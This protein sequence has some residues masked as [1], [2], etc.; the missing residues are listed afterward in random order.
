[1]KPGPNEKVYPVAKIAT[2][3]E[4]LASEGVSPVDALAG[5]RLSVTQLRSPATRVSANQVLQSYRNAIRLSRNPQFAYHTGLRFHVSTY[6]MY[7]FA[8]LSSPNFRGTMAFAMKYHQLAAPLV[9]IDFKEQDNTAMWTIVPK[10][11]P[12]TD[13]LLYKFVVDLQMA[14]HLS[15]HRDVMGPSFRPSELHF[16]FGRPRGGKKDSAIFDCPVLYGQPENSF[17]FDAHWLDGRPNLGNAVTYAELC[18]LCDR[19]ANELQLSAG[20]AGRIREIILVDLAQHT[21]FDSVAK[22]LK[23]STRSL[24]RKLQEEGTSFRDLVGEV[25]AQ[26]AI[27]YVRDTDLSIEEIAYAL[28]FSDASAFRHAFR[29][30]TNAAPQKFRRARIG[31]G[32]SVA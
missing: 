7:G 24:R 20:I 16:S 6:G 8:I 22:R 14:V 21:S 13:D 31:T 23:M 9:E 2:V 3:V 19:L 30:W 26:M 18:Q 11:Y 1:M 27:K 28:G 25:R 5:V 12:Q 10:P 17:A 32:S 4:S 29:R 15:L